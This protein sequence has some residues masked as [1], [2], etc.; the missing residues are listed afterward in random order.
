VRRRGSRHYVV[1]R[2]VSNQDV[3][4]VAAPARGYHG[5]RCIRLAGQ[6]FGTQAS[7]DGGRDKVVACVERGLVRVEGAIRLL[8][9]RKMRRQRV[10]ENG[11]R[12]M[13]GRGWSRCSENGSMAWI[14]GGRGWSARGQGCRMRLECPRL[15]VGS[16]RAKGLRDFRGARAGCKLHGNGGVAEAA[17]GGRLRGGDG[18]SSEVGRE[19]ARRYERAEAWRRRHGEGGRGDVAWGGRLGTTVFFLFGPFRESFS[20]VSPF[21]F[22]FRKWTLTSA[23]QY[24]AEV[25][26]LYANINGAKVL[27]Q[28]ADVALTLRGRG[29][30]WRCPCRP[31]IVIWH[32]RSCVSSPPNNGRCL[33]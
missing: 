9:E 29:R 17:W 30:Y 16:W 20:Q 33:G 10:G 12:G 2:R 18:R 28:N 5:A 1:R 13:H 25:T 31:Q 11:G 8:G 7:K 24:C 14:S 15:R 22:Q 32:L 19:V 21:Q 27:L 6:R 23:H 3:G 26:R 4:S